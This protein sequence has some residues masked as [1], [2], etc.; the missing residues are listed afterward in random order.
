ME[1]NTLYLIL[2]VCLLA[3]GILFFVFLRGK[4]KK[5][6]RPSNV[7]RGAAVSQKPTGGSLS[8][9]PAE[10]QIEKI[11]SVLKEDHQEFTAILNYLLTRTSPEELMKNN[12]LKRKLAHIELLLPHIQRSRIPLSRE[13]KVGLRST[14]S[15]FSPD[16]Q[17]TMVS[18]VRIIQE[19]SEIREKGGKT[20]NELVDAFLDKI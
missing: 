6:A 2:F 14:T 20:L 11:I 15:L 16:L 12:E 4:G 1:S 5:K 8:A 10:P 13:Q 18:V 17:A 7:Y 3:L 19:M 9:K